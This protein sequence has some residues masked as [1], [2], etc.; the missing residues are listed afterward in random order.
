MIFWWEKMYCFLKNNDHKLY[1]WANYRCQFKKCL[2]KHH[3]YLVNFFMLILMQIAIKNTTSLF[4]S[5]KFAYLIIFSRDVSRVSVR[6]I[7][8]LLLPVHR[9]LLMRPTCKFPAIICFLF[10]RSIHTRFQ[11]T[12]S[13]FS[14]RIPSIGTC[15]SFSCSVR[16]CFQHTCSHSHVLYMHVPCNYCIFSNTYSLLSCSLHVNTEQTCSSSHGPCT[17]VPCATLFDSNLG[18]GCV[19]LFQ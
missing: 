12:F 2:Q 11:Y 17:P 13:S 5:L 14:L 1:T 9:F 4:I 8:E 10:S 18:R 19:I 6:L 3:Q 15:S 7:R 16:T